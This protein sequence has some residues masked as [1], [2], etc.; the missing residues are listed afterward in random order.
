M[1]NYV[2]MF[3]SCLCFRCLMLVPNIMSFYTIPS[4]VKTLAQNDPL[5]IL[6]MTRS[7]LSYHAMLGTTFFV[8]CCRAF[9]TSRSYVTLGLENA[10]I[11]FN[12]IILF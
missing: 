1:N 11:L 6:Y 5:F 12:N 8:L 4:S 3:V 10:P 7:L 2:D 9:N